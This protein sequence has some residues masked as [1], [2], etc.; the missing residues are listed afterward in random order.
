[1]K[2]MTVDKII[3]KDFIENR[4]RVLDL[5]AYLDR[6]DRSD[7]STGVT[8]FRVDSLKRAIAH[9]IEGGP[10]RVIRAQGILSDQ[11]LLIRDSA[12]KNQGAFGASRNSCC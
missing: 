4:S 6:I 1:M 7:E 8:D 12:E 11:S 9:L 10:G 5:A 3:Q 2:K